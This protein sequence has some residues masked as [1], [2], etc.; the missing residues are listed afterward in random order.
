MEQFT[1]VESCVTRG[2]PVK[3]RVNLDAACLGPC[4]LTCKL[5]SLY[6]VASSEGV[7]S[8]RPLVPIYKYRRRHSPEDNSG[9]LHCRV[10]SRSHIIVTNEHNALKMCVFGGGGVTASFSHSLPPL[11]MANGQLHAPDDL[12]QWKYIPVLINADPGGRTI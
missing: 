12:S 3:R 1:Q 11:C 4:R 2:A 10:H 5:V 7:Y 9:Q 8:G 6:F